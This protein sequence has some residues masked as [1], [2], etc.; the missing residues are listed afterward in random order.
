[1]KSS[2]VLSTYYKRVPTNE[3][4]RPLSKFLLCFGVALAS[5]GVAQAANPGTNTT[6]TGQ[7]LNIEIVTP[8]DGAQVPLSAPLAVDG[9]TSLGS[10][11]TAQASIVYM[12]DV[13]GS[14]ASPSGLDCNN[15]GVVDAGDDFVPGDSSVGTTLDCEVGGIIALNNSL[16]SNSDVN[17]AVVAFGTSASVIQS[18]VSPPDAD[19]D[20]N[21]IP[22]VNDAL[23]ELDQ[24]GSTAF[25]VGAGTSFDNA[26]TATIDA[27][28]TRP[29]NEQKIAYLLTDG[30]S[31][32]GQA[33]A[34]V[35]NSEG[36]RI[37]GFA[38]GTG[39]TNC[40]G[41]TLEA[42]TTATGGSCTNVSDITQLSAMIGG[43]GQPPT[44]I[45]RVEVSLNSGPPI[46][47]PVDLLG[48]YS[49]E[50]PATSILPG[51][52]VIEA[53]VFADDGT[54]ATADIV[55][56]AIISDAPT[57]TQLCNDR[58]DFQVVTDTITI[59]PTPSACGTFGTLSFM[60][61]LTN[62]SGG[63]IEDLFFTVT[64]LSNG[65]MLC[66]ADDGPGTVGATFTVGD[67]ATTPAVQQFQFDIGLED[68]NQFTFFV[69][70]FCDLPSPP[71]PQ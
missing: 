12:V 63:P 11:P 56:N 38:V 39:A 60:A 14:T 52:N 6:T 61:D 46:D 2:Q 44:G 31:S 47:V 65:N 71:L 5:V 54:Q 37:E 64:E 50:F 8:T 17:V 22:D 35:A 30:Q 21:G 23:A 3:P 10:L 69:D 62:I 67:V 58:V 26:I 24:G 43:T 16:Q 36:I 4:L 59:D 57:S 28:A 48:Q 1:M 33:E 34:A 32:T 20:N 41:S 66:N 9:L 70:A 7:A 40:P 15:D 68:R 27:F 18:F 29:D 49:N 53:T 25:P 45:D 19:S 42:I 51:P 13:S 55:V